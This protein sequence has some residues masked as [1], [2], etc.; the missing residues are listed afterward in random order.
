MNKTDTTYLSSQISEEQI[1]GESLSYSAL[2]TCAKGKEVYLK[3]DESP[4]F[5]FVKQG[6]IEVSY[7]AND[8]KITV[9]LLGSDQFFGEIGF[10]DG[11]S[12]VRDIRA[13]EDAEI[14]VFDVAAME[15]MQLNAPDL[16]CRLLTFLTKS[17][18][19]K[20]RRVLEESEPLTGYGASLSTGGKSYDESQPIP[21]E[22]LKTAKWHQINEMVEGF[23]AEFF[24]ISYL[25][26]KDQSPYIMPEIRQR[27]MSLMDDFNNQV[28]EI[29]DNIG[30]DKSREMVWGYIFKEA[31]P[32][33]MRSRFGERT[34]YKPKGYAGDFNMIEMLYADEPAGDGK[35]GKLVDEWLTHSPAAKAIRGRRILLKNKL[36]EF[37]GRLKDNQDTINIMNLACGPNRELF[38]FISD[39]DYTEKIDAL[40][41]DIDTE[42][43]QFTNQHVNTFPHMASIRLMS[44]NLVKW[45]L[46]RV[47]QK[48]GHQDIIYSS[49]L[50][51]YLDSR[52]VLKFVN[53]CYEHLKP[54]GKLLLGNF[55]PNNPNRAVMDNILQWKLIHRSGDDLIAI[56]N[57]SYFGDQVEIIAEE[58][59]INL[60]AVGTRKE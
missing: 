22:F 58:Q 34:Y 20:F 51:D 30:D 21:A 28:R 45:A 46:G 43:L 12:R 10:F 35:I 5:Y 17:I 15:K 11:G 3:S 26:Q 37:T 19:G 54:D 36:R 40:C 42:A 55:S 47:Q 52:L 53:R 50:I 60:F 18:C 23:K 56:F 41:V 39:C 49:G 4:S 59:K 9:A 31:F 7:T 44:E 14:H 25:L 8:T 2:M 13:V 57:D 29:E 48:F 16:Y 32:Y 1:I 6:I 38:D 24:N 27:C 33:F